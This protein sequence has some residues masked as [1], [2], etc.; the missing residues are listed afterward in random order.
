MTRRRTADLAAASATIVVVI[1][2]ALVLAVVPML[3]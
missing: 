1:A 2:C 3:Q